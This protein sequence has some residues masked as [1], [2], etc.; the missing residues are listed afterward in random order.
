M[1]AFLASAAAVMVL[2]AAVPAAAQMQDRAVP[3][4]GAF[5]SLPTAGEQPEAG[6]VYEIIFDVSQGGADGQPSR[7]LDRVARF[8]NMLA[9]G[10]VDL[11]HRRIVAV[12]HGAATPS[13]MTDEAWARGHEGAANPNATLVAQLIAAG[14][15]VRICGQA[16]TAQNIAPGDLAN[17]VKID[18]AALMTIVHFQQRGYVLVVN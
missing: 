11:D 2:L 3:G 5:T 4:H 18:L 16:M 6:R 7:G 10:G 1:K 8:V 9:A 12:V 14:V 15:D 17:G 13:V